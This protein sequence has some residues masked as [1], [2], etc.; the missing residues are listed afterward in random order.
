[1]FGIERNESAAVDHCLEQ[2]IV[3][4]LR[5]A[6]PMDAVRFCEGG[7]ILDPL[8]QNGVGSRG[9]CDTWGNVR[10]RVHQRGVLSGNQFFV[11][12]NIFYARFARR[13]TLTDET[14]RV[15]IL[16]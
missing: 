8:R 10:D 11:R 7:D 6:A 16:G 3:F 15:F 9:T 5:T 13:S 1:K 2:R 12:I 14:S 4:F